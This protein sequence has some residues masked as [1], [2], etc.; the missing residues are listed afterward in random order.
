MVGLCNAGFTAR[1]AEIVHR[2]LGLP[3]LTTLRK[4]SVIRP[5]R[6]SPAIPTVAEIQENIDAYAAGEKFPS[7]LSPSNR[8]SSF[9]LC[10]PSS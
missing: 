4:H 7:G 9:D 5:L 2:A 10:R 3:G 6:A 8:P 1:L